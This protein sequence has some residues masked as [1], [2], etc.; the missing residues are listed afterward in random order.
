MNLGTFREPGGRWPLRGPAWLLVLSLAVIGAA[1]NAA[2]DATS[3][4]QAYVLQHV[5]ADEVVAALRQRLQEKSSEAR[6][7][8]DPRLNQILVHGNAAAQQLAT[9]VVRTLDQPAADPAPAAARSREVKGYRVEGDLAERVQYLQSRFPSSTGAHITADPRTQQIIVVAPSEVQREIERSLRQS[10]ASAGAG[11]KKSSPPAGSPE[12]AATAALPPAAHRL[13]H[14]TPHT[15]ERELA[16]LWG[17]QLQIT[18][19][20]DGELVNVSLNHPSE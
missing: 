19:V 3:Q 7:F 17:D 13:R 8:A 16:R 10:T 18:R 12:S 20:R 9:Q 6:V 14:V 5:A 11:S 1:W 4:V 15:F 2:Q